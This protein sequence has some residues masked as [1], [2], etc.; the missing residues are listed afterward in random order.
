MRCRK[1]CFLARRGCWAGTCASRCVLLDHEASWPPADDASRVGESGPRGARRAPRRTTCVR[2]RRREPEPVAASPRRVERWPARRATGAP[3]GRAGPRR[4]AGP[5]ASA[6]RARIGPCAQPPGRCYGAVSPPSA[7]PVAIAAA[8]HRAR[9]GRSR[10]QP[11]SPTTGVFHRCG[12]RCGL[13]RPV[14]RRSSRWTTQR[15]CGKPA[16]R[17]FASRCPRRS[18]SPRSTGLEPVSHRRR[19]PR[20]RRAQL[21]GAGAHRGPLPRRWSRARWPTSAAPSVDVE[22][23][24]HTDGDDRSTTR[25]T[26]PDVD[27]RADRR[28]S[29]GRPGDELDAVDLASVDGARRRRVAAVEPPL[30]LRGLRHRHLEPLRPRRRAAR[31]PRRRPGPT[32]RCSS[33]ATP[34]WARPTCCRPSPTTSTR[35][36]RASRC[37]TSPPRP[38]STSSSTPSAPTRTAEFKRRYREVDVL[39]VDDIQFIEGKEGLQEEFFHT[40][41]ALHQANRQ[42]VLSSDR[43]PDAISDARG[44][45]PQPL[46][47]GPDHRHP[48]ARPRDPPR[49]PPQEGR[50]ASRRRSPTTC[51]SSSPPTSPTTSASSRAPSSG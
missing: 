43:P 42:I 44:P 8:P 18:G 20:P 46:Q 26:A 47:D 21:G 50:E 16:P 39:L 36:T 7:E 40:F 9:A 17:C 33:T 38:S 6:D 19:P 35:T 25:S 45:A 11:A 34:G 41:N 32:T 3:T 27:D 5:L 14:G 2:C 13:V 51:S 24:V 10:G 22:I 49:H 23:E 12:R 37:A 30:H 15:S 28:R 31:W 48:A 29:R 4:A 1:P